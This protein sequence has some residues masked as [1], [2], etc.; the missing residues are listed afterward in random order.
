M[1]PTKT[2]YTVTEHTFR[3]NKYPFMATPVGGSFKMKAVIGATT[4]NKLR[5][6][7]MRFSQHK[8]QGGKILAVRTA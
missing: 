1:K 6:L 7:G 4:F 5:T 8:L 2:I 3:D